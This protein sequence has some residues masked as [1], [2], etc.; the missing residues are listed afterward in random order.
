MLLIFFEDMYFWIN[1]YFWYSC[2]S[3]LITFK[4]RKGT[5]LMKPYIRKALKK[6]ICYP[7]I[8]IFCYSVVSYRFIG[9]IARPNQQNYSEGVSIFSDIILSLQG[10]FTAVVFWAGNKSIA[11]LWDFSKWYCILCWPFALCCDFSG[12]DKFGQEPTLNADCGVAR[13][14]LNISIEIWTYS[15]TYILYVTGMC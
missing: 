3:G 15:E 12:V 10:F 14:L 6:L 2:F 13:F 11:R 5:S 1:C 9:D 7:V 8:L 4:A